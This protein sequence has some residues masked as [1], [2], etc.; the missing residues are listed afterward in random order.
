MILHQDHTVS[1]KMETCG[2]AQTKLNINLHFVMCFRMYAVR[3]YRHLNA[4][5]MCKNY[6]HGSGFLNINIYVTHLIQLLLIGK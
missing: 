5:L 3:N 4:N 2:T 1:P 6:A